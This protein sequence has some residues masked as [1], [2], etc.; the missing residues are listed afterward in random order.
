MSKNLIYLIL[1][2]CG[3]LIAYIMVGGIFKNEIRNT[4]K[5][6]Y[7]YELGDIKKID[8]EMI[9]YKESKR[10]GLS[11]PSPKAIDY[12][13]G[14]IAIGFENNLQVIDT[15]GREVYSKAVS[16]P[17]TCIKF[18]PE[19][20]VFA[21]CKDH[22][23]K[24][25]LNGELIESWDRLDTSAY[26]TSLVFLKD[27]LFVADA[28]GPQIHQYDLSGDILQ[29]FD[30]KNRKDSKHG[31]IIPSPYFDLD[32]DSEGQLWAANTGVQSIENYNLDG[33]LR[34]FWGASSYDL[35]GFIGCCNPAEFTILT[36]DYFVTCEK[37]L[38]RIKVYLPS[39][40]LESVVAT[41]KD[42]DVNSAPPDLASDENDNI[43]LLD[44]TRNMI[45]K[46]ER[47]VS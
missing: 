2:I 22:I 10:I 7:E 25:S 27:Y 44:L 19:N 33:S 47:K 3:I 32:V 13:G 21:G 15:T 18:S 28:G 4:V 9:K 31:F 11:F 40:E 6:P 43:L 24:Y 36:N 5:N 17:V 14:L 12:K 39:G 37:G 1:I 34:A 8:P 35:K 42:F 29:S 38:V 46:F 41:P 26:I 20:E 45:R 30:G 16:G 23:E